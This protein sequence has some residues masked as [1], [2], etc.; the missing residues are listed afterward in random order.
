MNTVRLS[1]AMLLDAYQND[2][3]CSH[4]YMR[5]LRD[6]PFKCYEHIKK[7]ISFSNHFCDWNLY[8]LTQDS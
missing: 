5:P 1:F 7:V 6:S 2:Y 3:N 8:L 4:F